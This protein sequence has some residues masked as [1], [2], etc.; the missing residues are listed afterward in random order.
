MAQNPLTH[1]R[2]LPAMQGGETEGRGGKYFFLTLLAKQGGS[3]SEALSGW[4]GVGYFGY[5]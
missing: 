2:P 4:V 1:P 5:I 3:T